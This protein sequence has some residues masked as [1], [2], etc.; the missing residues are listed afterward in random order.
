MP[1]R[2]LF[3]LV[4][5]SAP[6]L[7]ALGFIAAQSALLVGQAGT[8]EAVALDCDASS[9]AIDAACSY[10]P[11][12]IFQIAVH[13]TNAGSGYASYQVK[14]RWSEPVLKFRPGADSSDENQWPD[15]GFA[16]RTENQ[17]DGDPS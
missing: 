4:G 10:E 1:R 14:V 9:P 6:L 13:A 16:A 5:L 7:L 2:R 3:V 17:P 12:T 8:D 15:C 11:G